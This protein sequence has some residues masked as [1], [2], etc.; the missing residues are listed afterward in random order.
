MNLGVACAMQD[1]VCRICMTGGG[2]NQ[3]KDGGS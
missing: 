3:K 1:S 2:G